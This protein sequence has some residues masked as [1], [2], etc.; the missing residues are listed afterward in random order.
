MKHLTEFPPGDGTSVVIEVDEPVPQGG[1]VPA[2]RPGE[3]VERAAKTP[4]AALKKIKPTA[5]A[6]PTTL[7]THHWAPINWKAPTSPTGNG[8]AGLGRSS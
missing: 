1:L 5:G 4:E 7:R 2:A 8:A 3:V 6:V